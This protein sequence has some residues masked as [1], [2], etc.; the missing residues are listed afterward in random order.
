MFGSRVAADNVSLA[1][2]SFERRSRTAGK[3][4]AI[5][6]VDKSRVDAKSLANFRDVRSTVRPPREIDHKSRQLSV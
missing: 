2:H 4:P 6:S 5:D 3:L 1:V